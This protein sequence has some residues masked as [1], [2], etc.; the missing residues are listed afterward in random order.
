MRKFRVLV[1]KEILE[2]LTPYMLVPLVITVGLFMVLGNFVGKE[3]EKSNQA[4]RIIVVD[5]DRTDLTKGA[6][7]LIKSNNFDVKEVQTDVSG[8][9]KVAKEDNRSIAVIFQAGFSEGIYRGQRENLITYNIIT[10]F[11][12]MGT[13]FDQSKNTIFVLVNNYV[14]NDLI[15]KAVP[16]L[17]PNFLKMPLNLSE[18]VSVGDKTTQT[19]MAAVM[20]FISQQT[21]FIPI[22]LFIVILFSAQMV[23]T[24][25]ASEKE[26]KTLETLLSAPIS[27][28]TIVSAKL[29]AAGFVSLLFSLVYMIGFRGY[30]TNL[31]GVPATAATGSVKQAIEQLG[32]NFTPT[33]Y[34]MMGLTL[35]MGILCALAIAIILGVFAE[36]I[37]SIQTVI[38]PLMVLITIP[39]LLVMFVDINT[40]SPALKWVLYAIPFSHPFLAPQYLLLS[41]Y[42]PVIWGIIYQFVIFMIFVYIASRLFSSDLVLTLKLGKK[43]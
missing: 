22:I 21:Y 11:S 10:N 33:A 42:T 13:K 3:V 19:N 29:F 14:S 30:M 37:K 26:N 12:L 2:L 15:K 4:P 8:A 9:L 24:S 7:S 18:N 40:L 6:I 1:Q 5:A 25:I 28:Q 31:S 16:D 35:F 20:G 34:F 39:Y 38:T 27:R 32:L 23:A 41:G 43:K 17:D 36:D